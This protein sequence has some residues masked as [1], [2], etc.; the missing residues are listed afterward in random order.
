M[1][2]I[3]KEHPLSLHAREV[4]VVS[5]SLGRS[6][7]CIGCLPFLQLQE[8]GSA[9]VF[10]FSNLISPWNVN[11]DIVNM[12]EKGWEKVGIPRSSSKERIFT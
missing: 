7:T 3:N 1:W 10:T 6:V 8:A 12:Q 11:F 4:Y 9:N 5:Y 2:P